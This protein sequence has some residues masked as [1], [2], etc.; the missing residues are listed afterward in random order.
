MNYFSLEYLQLWLNHW[1]GAVIN[2]VR[3]L[4]VVYAGV[5]LYHYRTNSGTWR[6]RRPDYRISKLSEQERRE[7]ESHEL[8]LKNKAAFGDRFRDG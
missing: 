4:A 8:E 3:D 1:T 2:A 5:A 7:L 6:L